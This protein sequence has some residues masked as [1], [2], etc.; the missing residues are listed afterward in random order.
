MM[1]LEL[2]E[3]EISALGDILESYLSDLKAERVGTENR[4]W[5]ADLKE[6][7]GIVVDILNRLTAG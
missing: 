2:T 7:E 4:E 5:R 6:R 3:K 1:R